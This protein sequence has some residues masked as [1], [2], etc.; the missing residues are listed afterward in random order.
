[1]GLGTGQPG[2]GISIE[3][4]VL[5]IKFRIAVASGK[6]G[7]KVDI[8]V[9]SRLSDQAELPGQSIAL[10]RF[11]DEGACEFTEELSGAFRQELADGQ[12]RPG[13]EV[14]KRGSPA[15]RSGSGL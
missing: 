6:F 5:L 13:G 12:E 10:A 9:G 11:P 7:Q 8:L 2:Q 4:M 1:M 14:G 3:L 15:S